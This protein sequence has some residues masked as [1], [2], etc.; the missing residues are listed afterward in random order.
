[1]NFVKSRNMGVY[2][3]MAAF[4]IISSIISPVYPSED[5]KRPSLGGR[6][7][8]LV[9]RKK[10]PLQWD[11]EESRNIVYKPMTS[12]AA[13]EGRAIRPVKIKRRKIVNGKPQKQIIRKTNPQ[14]TI[15][16][17][18]IPA[19]NNITETVAPKPDEAKRCKG[20]LSILI[21]SYLYF[22]LVSVY[23]CFFQK[24]CLHL[25]HR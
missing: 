1:M 7:R 17:K 22:S 14:Q 25:P 10:Q 21:L 6:P 3:A 20:S 15:S 19:I 11:L 12:E 5:H 13:P 8:K 24:R 2:K 16:P 4:C 23:N 9:R 18:I